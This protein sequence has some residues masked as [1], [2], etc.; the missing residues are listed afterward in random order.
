MKRR[1]R[2][3]HVSYNPSTANRLAR[4][5]YDAFLN[6]DELRDKYGARFCAFLEKPQVGTEG[7]VVKYRR[8]LVA[9]A[10]RGTAPAFQGAKMTMDIRDWL[11]D[12]CAFQTPGGFLMGGRGAR[13][14]AGFRLAYDGVRDEI[15]SAIRSLRPHHVYV[16]GY[17][18]GGAL[19]T[20]AALD[21]KLTFGRR[22]WGIRVTMYNFGSPRVGNASFA[23]Y[24]NR[25]VV[26][27]H[28]VVHSGDVVTML[29]PWVT[30]YKHV[31]KRHS[32]PRHPDS[33]FPHHQDV[34]LY[35]LEQIGK[36]RPLG[37]IAG[38]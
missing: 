24:Y 8:N 30:G 25:N 6:E 34:K 10:F 28:R 29:P 11:I 2:Q 33:K 36:E 14:H 26:D 5:A 21:I 15:M 31:R 12:F 13:V 17:S 18:L 16:T 4:L 1:R 3:R 23:K 38:A 9:V 35:Y 20:L 37:S 22:P 7:F 32:L 19:A 27:S